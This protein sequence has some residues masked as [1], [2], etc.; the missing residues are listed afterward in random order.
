[1]K[2]KW[3]FYQRKIHRRKIRPVVDK[4]G[5]VEGSKNETVGW[6]IYLGDGILPF[7]TADP[8]EKKQK[9]DDHKAYRS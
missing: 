1:M 7:A 4:G 2:E 9:G 3:L 5:N 6:R 8:G